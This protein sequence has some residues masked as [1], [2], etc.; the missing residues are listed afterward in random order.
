MKKNLFLYL[1]IFAILINVFTYMYFSNKAKFDESQIEACENRAKEATAKHEAAESA[2]KDAN[3][4]ALETNDNAMEYFAGQDINA[5]TAKVHEGLDKMNQNKNGNPLI[6]Y[7]PIGGVPFRTNQV[8]ILNHRWVIADFSNG[9]A[10][11]ETLIKYFVDSDGNVSF[12]PMQTVLY[13]DTVN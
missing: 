8:K 1:F 4:F 11:G 6:D 10:W 9:S 13:S 2:L 3:Y 5:I 7:P 12:E